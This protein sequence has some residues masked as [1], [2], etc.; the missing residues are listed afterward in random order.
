MSLCLH[1]FIKDLIEK[2]LEDEILTEEEI[3]HNII[4]GMQEALAD[5]EDISI[6]S[7]ILS[8]PSSNHLH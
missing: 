4:A 8:A 2:I 5:S 7:E 6:V 3:V 1:C